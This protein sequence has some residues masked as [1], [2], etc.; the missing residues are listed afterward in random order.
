[1]IT[2]P[3]GIQPTIGDWLTFVGLV[4]GA[5]GLVFVL[6]QIRVGT[7]Q[8]RARFRVDIINRYFDDPAINALHYQIDNYSYTFKPESESW[9]E[10]TEGI[11]R[12]LYYLDTVGFLVETKVIS[13]EDIAILKHRIMRF[14]TNEEV[15]EAFKAMYKNER[16]EGAHKPAVKLFTQ[17]GGKLEM[18]R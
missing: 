18:L 16:V 17:L 7:R 5:I 1:M 11:S 12:T 6:V 15:Q 13:L 4:G 2:L 8:A 9:R 14:F 3:G 10:S